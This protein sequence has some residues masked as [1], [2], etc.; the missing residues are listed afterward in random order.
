MIIFASNNKKKIEEVKAIFGTEVLTPSELGIE[1]EILEDGT[2]FEENA[3]KKARRM[4]DL[5]GK[6]CIADDSGICVDALGG[7]PGVYTAM[8]YAL[9]N[10][11]NPKMED[12]LKAKSASGNPDIDRVNNEKLINVLDGQK[13]RKAHYVCVIAIAR[14]NGTDETVR[15][16]WQGEIATDIG[17]VN[18]FGYDKVFIHNGKRVSDMTAK[19][20]N[21]ISHRRKAL[22]LAR[23]V[24]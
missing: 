16:E 7:A 9:D 21:M 15:A 19:E 24:L 17:G 10:A 8:Y 4:R 13:N 22:E 14:G 20:K 23:Q 3:L 12:V 2:T 11:L 1:L 5:T 18:G 6:T